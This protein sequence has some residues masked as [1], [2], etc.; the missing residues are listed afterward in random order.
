MMD[1]Q[2]KFAFATLAVLIAFI[3]LLALYGSYS[4][5]YE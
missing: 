3:V 2:T 4:G 5:W 1:R